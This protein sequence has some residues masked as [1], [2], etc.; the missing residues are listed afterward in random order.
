MNIIDL[1]Q[2]II[3]N[4]LDNFY[5][6]TGSEIGIINTYLNNMSTTL[7]I[8]IQRPD[9]VLSIY[10]KCT[11]KSMFGSTRGFYVIRNDFIFIIIISC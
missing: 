7:K 5:V 3:Q 10:S 11:S 8:P 2:Q 6:F 9:T 4:K 1:K